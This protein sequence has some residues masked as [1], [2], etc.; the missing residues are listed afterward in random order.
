MLS[1]A[2]KSVI[3]I[4]CLFFFINADIKA[5]VGIIGVEMGRFAQN[6]N[7]EASVGV[8]NIMLSEKNTQQL[9]VASL[10]N[11]NGSVVK[12]SKINNS[13]TTKL[14]WRVESGMYKVILENIVTKEKEIHYVIL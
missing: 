13:F 3:V 8:I 12:V 11:E 5:Q 1:K 10:I 4:V 7:S 6:D 14:S 9:I 2:C